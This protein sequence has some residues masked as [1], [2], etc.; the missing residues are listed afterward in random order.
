MSSAP[1]FFSNPV[2]AAIQ[3]STANTARDGTGTIAT[4]ITG[5][6][7]GTLVDDLVLCAA[8]TVTNGVIRLWLHDGTNA[9]L[10]REILVTSTV[11]SATV[12]AWQMLLSDLGIIL[13]NTSWSLRVSTH[14]AEVF[15]IAITRAGTA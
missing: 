8:G 5:V 2:T 12:A 6:A 14:N 9:R 4:L 10:I 13:A 11:P 15:N 1:A 3:I 7:A